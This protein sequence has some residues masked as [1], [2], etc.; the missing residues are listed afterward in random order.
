M[1]LVL[2]RGIRKE[3]VLRKDSIT[4]IT[5]FLELLLM[6]ESVPDM[7]IDFEET[8]QATAGIVARMML[9]EFGL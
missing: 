4:K 3:K 1:N 6:Y 7:E 2:W 8:L 9:K 5:Q